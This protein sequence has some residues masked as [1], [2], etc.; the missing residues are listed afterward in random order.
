VHFY[1]KVKRAWDFFHFC[2]KKILKGGGAGVFFSFFHF[3]HFLFFKNY[4]EVF[5]LFL[6]FILEGGRGHEFF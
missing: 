2:F 5:F 6:L 1:L 3:F 4:L